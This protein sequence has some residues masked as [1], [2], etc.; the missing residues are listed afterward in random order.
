MLIAPRG[1]AEPVKTCLK[2]AL[3]E[4]IKAPEY[5]AQMDKFENEALNLGEKGNR[6]LNA[7]LAEFYA[8]MLR[9]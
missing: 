6:D 4:A 2:E 1:M 5:K 3:D 8:V 9:K 7:R